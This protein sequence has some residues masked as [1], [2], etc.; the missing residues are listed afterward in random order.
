MLLVDHNEA[1]VNK[2]AS[3][4]LY[5]S[6]HGLGSVGITSLF[7]S[8][9][10]FE[11]DALTF[12]SIVLSPTFIPAHGTL[13][14]NGIGACGFRLSFLGCRTRGQWL[15]QFVCSCQNT[16]CVSIQPLRWLFSGQAATVAQAIDWSLYFGLNTKTLRLE[17]TLILDL[18]GISSCTRALCHLPNMAKIPK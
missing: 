9:S 11:A 8:W 17:P 13:L 7:G 1:Q 18:V 5:R 15:A 14:H 4:F 3:T 16:A 2:N 12:L 10:V 6:C